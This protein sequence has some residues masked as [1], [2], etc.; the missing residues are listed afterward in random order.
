MRPMKLSELK[1]GKTVWLESYGYAFKTLRLV[2][3]VVLAVTSSAVYFAFPFY[4]MD[5]LGYNTDLTW[6]CW[7]EQPDMD[8]LAEEEWDVFV[9]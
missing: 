2:K 9:A 8:T 1:P 5:A 7:D 4:R 3:A 6:R